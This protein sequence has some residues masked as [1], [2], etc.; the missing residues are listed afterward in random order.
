M[1]TSTAATVSPQPSSNNATSAW[2]QIGYSTNGYIYANLRD[3]QQGDVTYVNLALRDFIPSG[4]WQH[5]ADVYQRQG[6]LTGKQVV[7]LRQS[8]EPAPLLAALDGLGGTAS[9]LPAARP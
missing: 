9:T 4:R 1:T 8:G 3:S 6:M 2:I 5:I 7:S